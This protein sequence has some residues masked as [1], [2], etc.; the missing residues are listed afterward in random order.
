MCV[1]IAFLNM[2]FFH[3]SNLIF[4]KLSKISECCAFL[5]PSKHTANKLF[6]YSKHTA[7]FF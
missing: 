1:K 5:A 4:I 6:V 7:K 2:L 3:M